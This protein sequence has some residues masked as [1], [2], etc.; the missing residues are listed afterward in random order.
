MKNVYGNAEEGF[1]EGGGKNIQ[2]FGVLP[3]LHLNI[4]E[5]QFTNMLDKSGGDLVK[6]CTSLCNKK[7][8]NTKLKSLHF[9][10]A[11]QSRKGIKDGLLETIVDSIKDKWIMRKNGR[12][13][14]NVIEKVQKE[15]YAK[16]IIPAS[17][18]NWTN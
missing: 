1:D 4:T 8:L 13:V 16:G 18:I 14:L 17:S 10:C 5:K 11:K 3:F 7:G 6:A 12:R 2:I 9:N 15:Q